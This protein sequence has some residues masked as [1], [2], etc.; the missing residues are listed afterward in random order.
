MAA[1]GL[2]SFTSVPA[3]TCRQPCVV[4]NDSRGGWASQ[5]NSEGDYE[6]LAKS[7]SATRHPKRDNQLGLGA[8]GHLVAYATFGVKLNYLVR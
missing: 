7:G 2:A 4:F 1:N 6:S 3:S 8:Y 5:D